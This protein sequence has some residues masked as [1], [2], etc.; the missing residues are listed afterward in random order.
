MSALLERARALFSGDLVSSHDRLGDDTIVV[1]REALCR[2]MKTLRDEPDLR[3]DQL[4]DLT[5]VDYLGRKTPRFE[6]VYHLYSYTHLH[7]LRVKVEVAEEDAAVDSMD[8]VWRAANWMERETWDLYGIRFIGHPD[9]RRILMYEEFQGHPL[10][11]DYPVDQ[12]Q[13]LVPE[14]EVDEIACTSVG[15]AKLDRNC[16][17]RTENY[18]AR[19]I[20][21]KTR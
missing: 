21:K 18:R 17:G 20:A 5:A 12:R 13:P 14:R 2:V 6:V 7:R 16:M 15:A 3:F 10:R 8:G 4:M 1:T 19:R 9:L 11:K